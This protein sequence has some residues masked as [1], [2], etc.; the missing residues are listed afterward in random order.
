MLALHAW[1]RARLA[2]V[3]S[4]SNGL[5]HVDTLKC[6]ASELVEK[7]KGMI[8]HDQSA[9]EQAREPQRLATVNSCILQRL[10]AKALQSLTCLG[11]LL[12]VVLSG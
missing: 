7:A 1:W 10:L 6:P 12:S 9:V 4:V 2:T 11:S 5:V 3:N 8:V